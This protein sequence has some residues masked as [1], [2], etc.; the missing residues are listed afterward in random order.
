MDRVYTELEQFSQWPARQRI[1]ALKQLLPKELMTQ[2]VAESSL[3]SNFCRRL[4]NWF[5]L[6]FVVAIGLFCTDS[7]RQVFKWLQPF[8]RKGT[9]RRSTLCM[10]R[11]RL[12]VA[13]LRRLAERVVTLL[14]TPDTPGAF[15]RQ[16]RLMGLDGFVADLPDSALNNRVFGRPTSGRATCAFPQARVLSLCELGTHVLWRSSIKPCRRGETTMAPALLR[17]LQPDMLL[18]WD[19]G[20]FSY[21]LIEQVVVTQKAQLLA[22]AKTNSVLRPIRTLSDGSF[23]A[24]VYRS[25]RHREQ[26]REG[27]EVRVIEYVLRDPGRTGDGQK[28]RLITT[29]WDEHL[30]P[31]R[32]LVVLYHQR[33]EEELTI[34]ELKT[35]QRQ[36]PVLRSQTPSGVV[37]ELYGLLA[38]HGLVR[39]A[40][41]EA[42]WRAGVSPRRVSFTGAL[43]ILRCRLAECPAD[44]RGRT[45]WHDDLIA[46]IAEELLP[47]RRTR[48]N[49][50]VI[51]K[52]MSNWAKKRP[53]HRAT[54][55]PKELFR[56][57]IVILR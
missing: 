17:H 57:T 27:I 29:L 49:P 53:Q 22:R 46:E 43:K 36:R 45:Q 52:K 54:T 56:D 6:W 12:G 10:A 2:V 44:D 13:P 47:K 55:K 25:K 37:Q 15:H 19:R 34:D 48:I 39:R 33:W 32:D 18:L 31:A 5:M 16:Y 51:K 41:H 50:R 23:V 9:P 3:P 42:A 7:Y 21:A 30:D 14:A 35:H 11:L 28:H 38:A 1:A 20:F 4:P 40:M 8:R 26:D 24:C